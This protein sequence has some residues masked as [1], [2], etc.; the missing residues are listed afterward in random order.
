MRIASVPIRHASAPGCEERRSLQ[1][2]AH[3]AYVAPQEPHGEHPEPALAQMEMCV[4]LTLSSDF[5]GHVR[6]HG[7]RLV[8]RG[9]VASLQKSLSASSGSV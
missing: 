6:H 8:A 4:S 3:S 2:Q 9:A 5:F 7:C 1:D